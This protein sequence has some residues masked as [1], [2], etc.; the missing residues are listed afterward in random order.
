MPVEEAEFVVNATL[1]SI[2]QIRLF[3]KLKLTKCARAGDRAALFVPTA[4]GGLALAVRRWYARVS[5]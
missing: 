1:D 5:Q 4:G 2:S 3:V